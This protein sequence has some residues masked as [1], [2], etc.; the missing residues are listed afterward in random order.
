MNATATTSH[1]TARL[2]NPSFPNPFAEPP[3]FRRTACT[4]VPGCRL[5]RGEN[6]TAPGN[7]SAPAPPPPA[8]PEAADEGRRGPDVEPPPGSPR[9][10]P[11]SAAIFPPWP[12]DPGFARPALG[13]L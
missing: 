5:I 7:G 3:V 11:R 8:P 9:G 1:R 2:P 6:P 13:P 12:A 4:N 10:D